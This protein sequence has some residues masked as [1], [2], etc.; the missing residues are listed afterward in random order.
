MAQVTDSKEA[1]AYYRAHFREAIREDGVVC[2]ECG[3][4]LRFLDPHVRRRHGMPLDDY[5]AKWGYNKET[6]LVT[7]ALAAVWRQ[8]AIARN[9]PALV[10]PGGLPK[11]WEAF[12]RSRSPL[13]LERRLN[14]SDAG[15]A[16]FARG[17][18]PPN[19]RVE[20]ET[21]RGLAAEG[22]TARQIAERVKMHPVAVRTRARRLGLQLSPPPRP[23]YPDA[24]ILALSRGGHRP[25]AIAART[26]L[27]V[28]TVRYRLLRLRQGV[29]TAPRRPGPRPNLRGRASDEELVALARAGLGCSTIAARTGL[30]SSGVALRL[31]KLRRQGVAVPHAVRG[32]LV[33]DEQLIQFAQAGLW[34][35]QIAGHTGVKVSTISQRLSRLRERGVLAPPTTPPPNGMRRVSDEVLLG[36]ALAGLSGPAIARRVGLTPGAV[37]PRL[38]SLRRRGLLPRP[39]P[40]TAPNALPAGPTAPR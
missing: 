31:R 6:A 29:R 2:L 11:A 25:A 15:K 9:L 19:K 40:A 37:Q 14:A 4:V 36:L 34:P 16:R 38:Q 3:V 33:D 24:E 28:G 32:P 13:R 30:S 8:H 17:W 35:G 5:K 22:L 26:G 10:P 1:L 27:R 18:R 20:D 12:R 39:A 23:V 7:P 21:L